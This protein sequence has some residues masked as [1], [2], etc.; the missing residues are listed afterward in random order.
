MTLR[1][2]TTRAALVM[3]SAVVWPMAASRA[4]S[5]VDVFA[6]IESLQ[7]PDRTERLA[8]GARREGGLT[9]YSSAT[10][11]DMGV[12]LQAFEK[13]YAIKARLWRGNSEG[14]LQRVIAEA[15]SGR[16]E[17]DLVET[18]GSA[19]EALHRE[20]VLQRLN[21]PVL[22]DLAP[23]AVLAHRAWAAT[24]IQI[25]PNG[26]NS[27]LIKP[28]GLPKSYE[29]LLDPRWKGKLGIEIDDSHWWGPMV[30]IMGEAKGVQLFRDIVARNGV[31]VRK[32]HSLMAS[33]TASGEVPMSLG[34]YQYRFEQMKADGAPVDYFHLAPIMAHGVGVGVSRKAPHPYSAALFFDFLLTD[35]QHL[36]ASRHATPSNIKVKPLPPGLNFV[37]FG[38]VLDAGDKWANLF[39]D[40]FV[41]KGR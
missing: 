29:D 24:R 27:S 14:I 18:G 28:A 10:M 12:F 39:R 17:L 33:L 16:D 11:E 15:R 23:Q 8:E 22:A 20:G 5:L 25:Q 6:A 36:L 37:D 38:K 31:S 2:R 7:G 34:I 32:G 26:Y 4:E 19:L 41:G 13:K 35:G 9:L 40:V 21:S 3:L 1:T 30:E